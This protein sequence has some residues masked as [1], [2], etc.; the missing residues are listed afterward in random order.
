M[1]LL[2]TFNEL[3]HWMKYRRHCS[4]FFCIFSW[5][6]IFFVYCSFMLIEWSKLSASHC[7][8]LVCIRKENKIFVIQWLYC[9]ALLF[10]LIESV[11]D[12]YLLIN[13]INRLIFLSMKKLNNWTVNGLPSL[14]EGKK[15]DSLSI[16]CH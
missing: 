13:G 16:W 15:V 10:F 2:Q 9:F 8:F 1:K 6:S 7:F 12:K 4:F 11:C 5:K 14:L 3:S